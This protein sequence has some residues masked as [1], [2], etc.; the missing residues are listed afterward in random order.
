MRRQNDVLPPIPGIRE[1]L[2]RAA[3]VHP[4]VAR[5][6]VMIGQ[7]KM[8]RSVAEGLAYGDALAV[9]CVGHAPH[10]RP[11]ALFVDVP[12]IEMLQWRSA[13]GDQRRVDD[14]AGG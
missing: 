8:R 12:A 14:W 11:G 1:P 5:A 9:E 3:A 6:G 7:R 2:V 4:F 13:H 10:G